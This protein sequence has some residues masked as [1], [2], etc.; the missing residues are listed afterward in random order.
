MVA[1]INAAYKT[2]FDQDSVLRVKVAA[3]VTF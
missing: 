3:C 1:G 2:R